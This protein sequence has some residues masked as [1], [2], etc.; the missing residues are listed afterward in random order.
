MTTTTSIARAIL[1]SL[2]FLFSISAANATDLSFDCNE[3][4]KIVKH[5][6]QFGLVGYYHCYGTYVVMY[7]PTLYGDYESIDIYKVG[8]YFDA[9]HNG[10][11][12]LKAICGGVCHQSNVLY[13][14]S[15][16]IIHGC[17]FTL[18]CPLA[19]SINHCYQSEGKISVDAR[20]WV[21]G[22]HNV[23]YTWHTP[24]GKIN[25][26]YLNGNYGYGNFTL[27]VVCHDASCYYEERQVS[28]KLVDKCT[29]HCYFDLKSPISPVVKHCFDT[30]G[31][32][33]LDAQP[34]VKGCANVS[35]KWITPKGTY[36][37]SWITGDFGYGI[38][39]L[40]VTCHD[41]SCYYEKKTH[42]FVLVDDC[43][44][45]HFQMYC[46]DDVYLDCADELWNLSAFGNAYY[47]YNG[48]K[49]SLNS[50]KEHRH[51]N[52]CNRGYVTREW[53]VK[54]HVGKWHSCEQKI[55]VG[56]NV[57]GEPNIDWPKEE[58]VLEGCNPAFTPQDLPYGA[59]KPTYDNDGC[60]R[61][62]HNYTDEVFYFNSTCKKVV[63]K[64]IVYDWCVYVPNSNSSKGRYTFYQTIKIVNTDEP[65]VDMP[66]DMKV[67]SQSCDKGRVDMDD[68]KVKAE[69]CGDKFEIEHNSP[70]ADKKGDNA[71]GNYPVGRT[72]VTY[73][74]KY[75]CGYTKDYKQD[76]IVENDKAPVPYCLESIV[77]PLMGVDT[78]GDGK[79][80]NGEAEI[81]AKDFDLGAN[82]QCGGDVQFSFSSDEIVMV[83][84]FTCDELGDN[85]LKIYVSNSSGNKAYC[86]VNLTIQNNAANIPDCGRSDGGPIDPTEEDEEEEEIINDETPEEEEVIAEEESNEMAII[87]GDVN[88]HYGSAVENASLTL[89]SNDD[90][91]EEMM[92]VSS[93][94]NGGYAFDEIQMHKSYKITPTKEV[95]NGKYITRADSDR[96]Y[97]HLSGRNPITDPYMLLAADINQSGNINFSDL[98][99]IIKIAN[100]VGDSEADWI[101]VDADYKF[102]DESNPWDEN[103]Q[104]SHNINQLDEIVYTA[105]FVG[106]RLGDLVD[107]NGDYTS[108]EEIESRERFITA[109]VNPNPFTYST[110]ITF[111]SSESQMGSLILYKTNGEKVLERDLRISKGTESIGLGLDEMPSAGVYIYNIVLANKVL[112][113]K[114]LRIN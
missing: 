39:K 79:V 83:K 106:I 108:D 56:T 22:C 113:G 34:W 32:I 101:F 60:S 114:L 84:T 43:V 105:D 8:T 23:S 90:A 74:V 103:Y 2:C 70:Y 33:K 37:S 35:Y 89:Y 42:S 100:N 1:L 20:A 85:E 6:C 93:A 94:R 71:S 55:Y 99:A 88:L 10:Y 95:D 12:K 9:E 41:G 17:G 21:S 67:S 47:I 65:I 63:R 49:V 52:E 45:H 40:E 36:H 19:S 38:Y 78:D 53:K 81:W 72:I 107:S 80:D 13:F 59:Q 112:K 31:K 16:G 24:I 57:Y 44:K 25:S 30:E 62:G 86:V 11:Y 50:A 97:D 26:P 29:S 14:N 87:F 91:E 61:F 92:N 3:D 68:L 96:L 82:D 76:V 7:S 77:T 54:D 102:D 64:W 27:S 4:V 66:K 48:K 75:G 73:K 58:V 98:A 111:E 46:P 69:S 51:L 104:S 18:N 5:G 109:V 15:C 110:N 28:F